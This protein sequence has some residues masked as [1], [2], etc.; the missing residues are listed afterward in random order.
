MDWGDDNGSVSKVFILSVQGPEF[1]SEHHVKITQ[2]GG[3]HLETQCWE[4]GYRQIPG[5]CWSTRDPVLARF[6]S[7]WHKIESSERRKPQLRK[8]SQKIGLE[9]GLQGISI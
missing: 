1:D 9:A 5:A 3:V 8:G 6:M 2:C 7:A 4:G